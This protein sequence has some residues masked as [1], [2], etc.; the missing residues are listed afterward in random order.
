MTAI[1][2]ATPIGTPITW[3]YRRL[4][5]PYRHAQDDIQAAYTAW[6]T[7]RHWARHSRT[8]ALRRWL[9]LGGHPMRADQF[10]GIP[11]DITMYTRLARVHHN[12]F[13]FAN[14]LHLL[15]LGREQTLG[16]WAPLVWASRLAPSVQIVQVA[17]LW[18]EIEACN[19]WLRRLLE[20]RNEPVLVYRSQQPLAVPDTDHH[21]LLVEEEP[22]Q[23][24]TR[25]REERTAWIQGTMRNV[26]AMRR[27]QIAAGQGQ[28][29]L[30][31][32]CNW[33]HTEAVLV[34]FFEEISANP[35]LGISLW[36][37]PGDLDP[38]DP[39][40]SWL[41]QVTLCAL[42][43]DTRYDLELLARLRPWFPPELHERYGEEDRKDSPHKEVM[44]TLDR[45][46]G[47]CDLALC[48]PHAALRGFGA[49]AVTETEHA[50]LN[51]VEG[52]TSALSIYE[53]AAI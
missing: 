18:R 25:T 50:C 27:N 1:E 5:W 48:S 44:L 23:S 4:P 36:W 20:A 29:P 13:D 38:R 35:D 26:L 45:Y 49:F 31:L 28:R 6:L 19:A 3:M 10:P 47:P 22:M 40:W 15:C 12:P 11:V 2:T 41:D 8:A 37:L 39:L 21:I 53:E 46:T 52:Y 9:G 17:G 42:S 51:I 33:W 43:G 16:E 24:W 7:Q 34:P 32:L 30:V 14:P